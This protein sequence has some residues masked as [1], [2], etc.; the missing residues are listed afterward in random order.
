M[1][2]CKTSIPDISGAVL[3]KIGPLRSVNHTPRLLPFLETHTLSPNT[4]TKL[5]SN[6]TQA[7]RTCIQ[8]QCCSSQCQATGSDS[9][10]QTVTLLKIKLTFSSGGHLKRCWNVET[11]FLVNLGAKTS[12]SDPNWCRDCRIIESITYK[13]GTLY[14]GRH[15]NRWTNIYSTVTNSSTTIKK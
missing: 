15:Y 5:K 4:D 14:S 13:P 3:L 7:P 1:E 8:K 2:L 6:I 11:M 12:F 9:T 10:T